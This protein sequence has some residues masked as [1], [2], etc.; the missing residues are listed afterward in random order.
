VPGLTSR[1]V[2]PHNAFLSLQMLLLVLHGVSRFDLQ[3]LKCY[4]KTSS[5]LLMTLLTASL[6]RNLYLEQTV[7]TAAVAQLT[8]ASGRASQRREAEASTVGPVSGRFET[9]QPS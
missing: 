9:P 1:T 3:Q 6:W 4:G 7:A 8:G 5:L 2:R